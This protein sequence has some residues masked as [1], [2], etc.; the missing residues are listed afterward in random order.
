MSNTIDVL[1]PADQEG[2]EAVVLRWLKKVGDTVAQNE[3]LLELET[4][5]VTV[6][7]PAPAAGQVAEIL[8]KEQ[9][10]VE[11]GAVLGR[12]ATAVSAGASTLS[13]VNSSPATITKQT[14]ASQPS[15]ADAPLSPAVK[16][17]L[18]EHGLD[19]A[20]IPSTGKSGRL[21][22]QDITRYLDGQNTYAPATPLP[23]QTSGTSRRVP[24]TQIRKRIAAHMVESMTTAPHVTTLFE[25]DLSGVIA[26]RTRHLKDFEARG[27]KLTYTAY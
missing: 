21:T 3:P 1:G 8:R 25:V 19:P 6:E 14:A 27:V 17:M 23:S 2:T 4:D 18:A 11:P 26:H 10:S 5:K 24:H 22:A 15:Q 13:P 12:I 7:V 16:R 20:R 9:E